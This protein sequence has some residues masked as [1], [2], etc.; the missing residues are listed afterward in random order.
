M[1]KWPRQAKGPFAWF[2]REP[3]PSLSCE[4]ASVEGVQAHLASL[5]IP[6]CLGY[7]IQ[8]LPPP[9]QL[10]TPCFAAPTPLPSLAHLAFAGLKRLPFVNCSS[11]DALWRL[12]SR[13]TK[14][15]D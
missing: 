9:A 5:C 14:L 6:F 4:R 13:N 2:R 3:Q 8:L 12:T 10:G 1:K 11:E 15:K 7:L